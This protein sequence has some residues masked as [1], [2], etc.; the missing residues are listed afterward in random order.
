MSIFTISDEEKAYNQTHKALTEALTERIALKDRL[1]S[2]EK[3]NIPAEFSKP[4]IINSLDSTK[5]IQNVFEIPPDKLPIEII[6]SMNLLSNVKRSV[7]SI[8]MERNNLFNELKKLKENSP[9]EI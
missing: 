6:N 5:G 9:I 3:R 2:L 7:E 4:I 1:S 8:T